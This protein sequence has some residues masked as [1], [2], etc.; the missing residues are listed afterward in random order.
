MVLHVFN[1]RTQEAEAGISL[2]LRPTWSTEREF[3]NSQGYIEKLCFGERGE[4]EKETE[5]GR[6]AG[7]QAGRQ[8]ELT[9]FRNA[10]N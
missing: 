9:V 7:M 2:S 8:A 3:Q 4:R 10:L 5:T 6:Q 1:F